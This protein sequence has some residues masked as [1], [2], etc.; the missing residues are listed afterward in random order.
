MGTRLRR[1]VRVNRRAP[2]VPIPPAWLG[3]EGTSQTATMDVELELVEGELR[4]RLA[5]RVPGVKL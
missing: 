2:K 4:V 5:R 1:T 3:D